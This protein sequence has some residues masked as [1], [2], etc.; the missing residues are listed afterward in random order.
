MFIGDSLE[1]C[2]GEIGEGKR[3]VTARMLEIKINLLQVKKPET[4]T[5]ASLQ[6]TAALA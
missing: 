4:F 6:A 3:M 2:S 5:P 1:N